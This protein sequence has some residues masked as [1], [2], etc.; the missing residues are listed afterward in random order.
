MI[1]DIYPYK[2]NNQ[3]AD[4]KEP[5]DDDYVFC[6][7]SGNILVSSDS[8][9]EGVLEFPKVK[10]F[11][12][13]DLTY[14]F[15][16]SDK[17]Y[18]Y[19]NSDKAPDGYIYQ[20]VRDTKNKVLSPDYQVYALATAKHIH[21]WYRDN[22]YCGR[23][24]KKMQHSKTERAMKCEC[25]YTCYPRIMP[26]VIVGVINNDSILLT[27][28]RTGFAH[29]ALVAGFVEIG[30]TLE[31]TVKREVKE[32]TGIN[33]KNIRYYKSQ[34]WGT[35]NDILMGFYCYLDGDETIKMDN[36]ELK[37][38][39]WVKRED[40]VLQPDNYSL[41]NEMMRMFKEGKES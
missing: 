7:E 21:D 3:Y 33:V 29:N 6:F 17:Q 31:E 38:A 20:S 22:Q 18:F 37:Y 5:K 19:I 10:D 25:G 15:S 28:Y 26:A 13:G 41:T 11:E 9:K 16:I 12:N 36:N 14:Y 32:E 30:E 8:L 1:Q 27:K 34:P 23:C 4:R 35:A 2:L 24:G 39:E 40:I